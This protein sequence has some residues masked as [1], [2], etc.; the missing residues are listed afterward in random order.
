VAHPC[1]NASHNGLG[2][3]YPWDPCP[4]PI[5]KF[6][7]EWQLLQTSLYCGCCDPNP[8]TNPPRSSDHVKT[9]LILKQHKHQ[10]RT[11]EYS[12]CSQALV[13]TTQYCLWP[14]FF[15]LSS[16][17][18]RG[19]FECLRKAGKAASA[20]RSGLCP[21][22]C[23]LMM[24]SFTCNQQHYVRIAHRFSWRNKAIH[25]R[26]ILAVQ[27]LAGPPWTLIPHFMQPPSPLRPPP[28]SVIM[29]QRATPHSCKIRSPYSEA[30]LLS[31]NMLRFSLASYPSS[32]TTVT[33]A[34]IKTKAM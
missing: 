23:I 31:R 12:Q 21:Q 14:L 19:E 15:Q 13:F 25:P 8:V 30:L 11:S 28:R 2:L 10:P 33:A 32:R 34:M 5:S 24:K 20:R 18:R 9:I 16:K 26:P 3:S 4:N 7:I 22:S 1:H 27:T 29:P 17:L 6:Q